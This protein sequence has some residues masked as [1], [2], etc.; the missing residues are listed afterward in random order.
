MSSNVKHWINLVIFWL[1]VTTGL[2]SNDAVHVEIL[3]NNIKQ[4]MIVINNNYNYNNAI[5]DIRRRISM[6][7]H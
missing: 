3:N 7:Y 6:H 1:R 2:G 4:I 5:E